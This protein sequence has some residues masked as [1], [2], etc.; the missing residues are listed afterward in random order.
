[1]ATPPLI[2]DFGL[3]IADYR[4]PWSPDI[5]WEGEF[6]IFNLKFRAGHH[7]NARE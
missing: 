5:G 1:M 3:Q 2:A 7:V 4:L 6:S